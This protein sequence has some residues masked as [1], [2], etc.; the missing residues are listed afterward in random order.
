[1]LHFDD[2]D[3]DDDDGDNNNNTDNNNNNDYRAE[4]NISRGHSSK[5]VKRIAM[6][7]SY[8]FYQQII[9]K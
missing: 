1:V 6:I 8:I 5:L 2:D 9:N 7:P 4:D 3:N